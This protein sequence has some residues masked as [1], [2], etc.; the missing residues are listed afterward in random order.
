MRTMKLTAL[1]LPVLL[2]LITSGCT[3][4]SF[5][6]RSRECDPDKRLAELVEMYER[7][8]SGKHD[9]S[10]ILLDCDRARLELERL[11]LEFPHHTPTLMVNAVYAYDAR[12]I[13]KAQRYLDTLFRVQ[14]AHAHAG[15]LRSRIAIAEG[16][17]PLARRVLETQIRYAPDQAGLHETYSFV[18][19]MSR[20]YEA[21]G[22]EI[23]LA[24]RLGAPP[25]RVAFNRGLIAEESGQEAE[26]RRQY[27]AALDANPGH[28][29]AKSRL[30]GMN[31]RA[32]YNRGTSL[33]G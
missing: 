33:P 27:Q 30:S 28:Q 3:T 6:H 31:A 2:V 13:E 17:L 1:C 20:E 19:Y 4:Y 8:K 18:L 14:P 15:V 26:A 10:D 16:N 29:E 9:S 21:A 7:G 12:E 32:G 5:G 11:S 23:T 25:W 22:A 24:E